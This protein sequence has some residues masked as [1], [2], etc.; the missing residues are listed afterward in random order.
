MLKY[1]L[2]VF[3]ALYGLVTKK[4]SPPKNLPRS[5]LKSDKLYCFTILTLFDSFLVYIY[6]YIYIAQLQLSPMINKTLLSLNWI[7]PLRYCKHTHAESSNIISY[8]Y[9]WKLSKKITIKNHNNLSITFTIQK[10]IT[11]FKL[12]IVVEKRSNYKLWQRMD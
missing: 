1:N 7:S 12:Q 4:K 5:Q 8:Q 3:H 2:K 9:T 10:C 11:K 6:I